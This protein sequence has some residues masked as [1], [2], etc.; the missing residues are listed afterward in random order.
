MDFYG[1]LSLLI[2]YYIRSLAV[3]VRG[4]K[5]YNRQKMLDKILYT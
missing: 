4:L 3:G 5:T 1:M 2:F